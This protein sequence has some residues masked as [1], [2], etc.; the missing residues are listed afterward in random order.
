MVYATH[1]VEVLRV[2]VLQHTCRTP[3]TS[4][5]DNRF[6]RRIKRLLHARMPVL[7]SPVEECTGP[8]DNSGQRST[9]E[10]RDT[11]TPS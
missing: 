3:S 7:G 4:Q 6:L 11:S 10:Y 8:D 2:H 5:D 9:A 1:D